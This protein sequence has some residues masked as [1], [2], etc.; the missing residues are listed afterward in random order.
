MT[1][2]A[3]QAVVHFNRSA[4]KIR[5]VT[6]ADRSAVEAIAAGTWEGHDY[7]PDVFDAWLEDSAGY[8]FAGELEGRVVA[9][10][11]LA[12][13]GGDQWWME[14]LRV[15]P[16]FRGLG[17][18]R[19]MHHYVVRYS[20]RF[21]PG[22]VRFSTGSGNAAVVKMAAETGFRQVARFAAYG[23][24]A[25]DQIATGQLVKLGPGDID[26]A[27]SRLVALPHYAAAQRTL[28]DRWR[29]LPLTPD[30]LRD[31]LA[32]GQ[33][34]GWMRP[35]GQTLAGLVVLDAPRTKEQVDVDGQVTEHRHLV[36]G[37]ADALH[38]EFGAMARSLRG[39][40]ASA[41]MDRVSW[42]VLDD[43]ALVMRLEAAGY[44]QRWDMKVLLFE[45]E[46]SLTERAP[47]EGEN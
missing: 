40:A 28:E 8:F 42:K 6:Q 24:A 3:A 25:D 13:F 21:A 14:G 43:P 26:R 38:D 33:V 11:R 37:F 12:H 2:S 30:L 39:L 27:W 32:E 22:I 1:G 45:R 15:D 36:V 29:F 23:A 41:G 18:G 20:R 7:L 4:F 5:P 47:L 34:W 44:E 17:I 9:V 10:A 35:D 19:I 46:L 16:S 31:R